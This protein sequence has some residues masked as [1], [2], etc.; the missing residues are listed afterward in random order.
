[1]MLFKKREHLL[2][3]MLQGHAHLS[4]KDYGFFNNMQYI[5]KTNNRVTSNQNKLFD[6]LV[7]K[8]QRQLKK[9]GHNIQDLL[10]LKWDV[11]V[12]DSSQEYLDASI[13]LE[14]NNINIRSP[15][16]TRFVTKFRQV[17]D[18]S[19]VWDKEKKVYTSPYSTYALKIAVASVKEHFDTIK[20]SADL[21]KLLDD[22]GSYEESNW[23]PM[24]KRVNGF[25]YISGINQYLYD[26]IKDIELNDDP[27]T[28]YKLSQHG[29][30]ISELICD[31]PLKVFASSYFVTSDLLDIETVV[32]WLT[33]LEVQHVFTAREV[34]YNKPISNFLKKI[35]LENGI[36]SSVMG[37]TDHASGVLFST[38]S[39]G[40]GSVNM[41]KVDKIID[42][43]NSNPVEIK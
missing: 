41:R 14:E 16:N 26:A 21:Q 40:A 38:R 11:L 28:L 29:V 19:F 43:T 3:Y 30:R 39:M 13:Q 7:L 35:L 2:H 37:S 10:E 24:L 33:L 34:I 20:F 18:N 8:Y 36:T 22:I 25:Y 5:V 15:F 23:E 32:K 42:F 17:P 9:L 31:D 27:K 12:I 1:M 4:K 6:K